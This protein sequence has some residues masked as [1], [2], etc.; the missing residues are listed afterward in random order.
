ML[1]T[2]S[3]LHI[4]FFLFSIDVRQFPDDIFLHFKERKHFYSFKQIPQM[5]KISLRI[6]LI[7]AINTQS[8]YWISICQSFCSPIF[9]SFFVVFRSFSIRKESRVF[10][11]MTK[12]WY[13]SSVLVFNIKISFEQLN[14]VHEENIMF[15]VWK[16][17]FS[18]ETMNWFFQL[19]VFLTLLLMWHVLNNLH[20]LY[21]FLNQSHYGWLHFIICLFWLIPI[22]PTIS[23]WNDLNIDQN[24][25]T[26]IY[27][28]WWFKSFHICHISWVYSKQMFT[29]Y[30]YK[31][32]DI[33]LFISV[34]III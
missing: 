4:T 31:T 5:E 17:E 8:W 30:F 21:D 29:A 22:N 2:P 9:W 32:N 16:N 13:W 28:I 23:D 26:V 7:R 27:S 14:F 10:N 33:I 20:S 19:F 12:K 25:K 11:L 15:K 24:R 34:M 6:M 3:L 18:L 1:S